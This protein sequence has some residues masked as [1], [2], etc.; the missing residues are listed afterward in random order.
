M[1]NLKNIY[2]RHHKLIDIAVL[3]IIALL[4]AGSIVLAVFMGGEFSD[5]SASEEDTVKGFMS[6]TT[7]S[8]ETEYD[9]GDCFVFDKEKSQLR[10]V[11]KDPDTDT[12]IDITDLE[13]ERYG[14]MINGE[15][16]FYDDASSVIM[17]PDVK[18]IAV[19][20]KDYTEISIEIEVTVNTIF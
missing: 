2:N 6:F 3:S 14:F 12:I 19:V 15:G 4:F 11:F 1:G 7:S 17:H 5:A 20:S 8:Y 18:T 16:L 9:E 10:L 13:T